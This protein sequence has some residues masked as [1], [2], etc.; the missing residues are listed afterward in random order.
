MLA[1]TATEQEGE[2]LQAV[3]GN[4][5][6]AAVNPKTSTA[7]VANPGDDTMSVLSRCPK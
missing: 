5:G 4:L 2:P 7:Y 6:G 3:G 1:V